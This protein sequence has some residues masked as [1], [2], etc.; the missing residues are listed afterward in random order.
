MASATTIVQLLIGSDSDAEARACPLHAHSVKCTYNQ[1]LLVIKQ[2]EHKVNVEF[3]IKYTLYYI[4]YL[5]YVLY[6]RGKARN[7]RMVSFS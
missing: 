7:L 3:I 1:P 4:I 5:I 2:S 6:L